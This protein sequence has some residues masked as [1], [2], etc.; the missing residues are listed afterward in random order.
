VFLSLCLVR[1]QC[2]CGGTVGAGGGGGG[3]GVS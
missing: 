1:E 3:P 2:P